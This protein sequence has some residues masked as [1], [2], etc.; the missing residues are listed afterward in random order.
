MGDHTKQE[1]PLFC[2]VEVTLEWIG[3]KYKPL[4]LWHLTGQVLRFGALQKL[5]PN[6]SM[7]E[8]DG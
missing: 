8:T 7:S 4:I 5:A 3:G 1:T 6:C 2:P